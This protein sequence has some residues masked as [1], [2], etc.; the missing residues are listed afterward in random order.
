[1]Q[2]ETFWAAARTILAQTHAVL[3]PGAMTAWMVGDYVR[4][5]QRVPFSQQWLELATAVGFTPV[6]WATV[7]KVEDHGTQLDVFG[8]ATTRRTSRVGF[9]RRLANRNNPSAA[10][11]NE[12]V[13]FLR[14][15]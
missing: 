8:G 10:I 1:V 2:G 11:E 5:G 14:R 6:L 9:F 15:D 3:R 4:D 12:E 7:W 13:L